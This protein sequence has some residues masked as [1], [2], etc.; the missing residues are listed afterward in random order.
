MKKLFLLIILF[1]VSIR[2]LPQTHFNNFV[3]RV[4]SS[5]DTNF[6]SA[7]VDSFMNYAKSSGVPFI[8]NDTVCFLYRG[9]AAQVN[10]AGD[11]TNWQPD[12]K[13]K[14]LAGTNLFYYIKTFENNA[15]L[16][17]KLVVDTARWILD[18]LNP[19]QVAGG[20]GQNSELAM[21]GYV[22]PWEIKYYD[23]EKHGTLRNQSVFSVLTSSSY[24]LQIYLP[25]GYDSVSASAYPSVY[26]QDGTDYT[27]LGDAINILDNLIDSNK[28]KPVI[29][30]FVRPNNRNVEYAESKRNHYASFFENELTHF[31][32]SCYNTIKAPSGRLVL[33]DSFG[34]NIS[35]LIAYNRPD[36]FGNCGL[37]SAAFWPNKYEVYNL[38][39][40]GVA[41]DVKI[42]SV[43]GSYESLS[44]NLKDFDTILS[45]KGYQ[46]KCAEYP[47]GHSWGL[48]KA[49]L[50][51]MLIYFFPA[52]GAD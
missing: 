44:S 35:A 43:W 49:H 19:N 7:E 17:Y 30:I 41:K 27:D 29:G 40:N 14:R 5:A 1:F 21:P 24:Q 10:L 34:G 6:K 11:F 2:V 9:N 3:Q 8:E 13:L 51:D 25:P 33:G 36:V 38:I 31:I 26:F 37:Q 28:I 4:N 12:I 39:T 50:D 47:E 46:I 23:N 42:H 22:K 48:W 15:R 16:D 18:P 32:D 52:K 20:Y 45:K